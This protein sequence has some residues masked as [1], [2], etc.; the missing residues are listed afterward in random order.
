MDESKTRQ[1][2]KLARG[3]PLDRKPPTTSPDAG[4]KIKPTIKP[5]KR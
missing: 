3:L 1:H 4:V 2:Y 5:K